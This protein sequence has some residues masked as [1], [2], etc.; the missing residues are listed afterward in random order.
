MSIQDLV[1]AAVQKALERHDSKVL[2]ELKHVKEQMNRLES[3]VDW[4]VKA[5][6]ETSDGRSPALAAAAR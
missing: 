2:G 1:E 4:L 3:A 6:K 5:E